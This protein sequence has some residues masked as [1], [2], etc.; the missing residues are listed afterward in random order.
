MSSISRDHVAASTDKAAIPTEEK[1]PPV[2]DENSS[3]DRSE[4][5]EVDGDYGSYSSHPFTDP[6]VAAYWRGI[7]ERAKYEGRHRFDPSLTWTATEEKRLKRRVR[8][9]RS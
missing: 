5:E 3:S 8:M 1:A 4:D 6:K 9:P 2:S 7:Y